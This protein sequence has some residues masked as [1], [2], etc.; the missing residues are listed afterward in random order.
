M[1]FGRCQP[2]KCSRLIAS[3]DQHGKCV[4]CVGLAHARDAIFGI[5]NCK[6]CEN[7]ILKTLRARLMVFDQESAILPRR[8]A[9]EASFLQRRSS[10]SRECPGPSKEPVSRVREPMH[11]PPYMV[12][13]ARGYPASRQRPRKRVDLKR[14]NKPPAAASSGCSWCTYQKKESFPQLVESRRTAKAYLSIS[15]MLSSVNCAILTAF[16]Q[17]VFSSPEE[18]WG[19]SVLY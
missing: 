3:E 11:P 19:F 10:S 1:D 2:S 14:P 8:V 12:W 5:S 18:G 16:L 4:W 13:G 7:F 9:P 17:P 15:K 6:Y